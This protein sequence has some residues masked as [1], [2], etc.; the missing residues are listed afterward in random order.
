MIVE[1]VCKMC[2]GRTVGQ[3]KLRVQMGFRP[4]TFWVKVRG[5]LSRTGEN[6]VRLGLL[7]IGLHQVGDVRS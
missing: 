2:I 4:T 1:G 5:I 3:G 6:A 7:R